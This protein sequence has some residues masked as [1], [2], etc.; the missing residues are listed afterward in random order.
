M[1][2]FQQ[3][4]PAFCDV[5]RPAPVPFETTEDLLALE[6]VRRY[7]KRPDF[8]HFAMYDDALMEISDGGH[9]WWLV[10]YVEHPEMVSLPK[11]TGGKYRAVLETG[12]RVDLESEDVVESCGDRLTLRD[13]TIA[14]RVGA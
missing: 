5:D 8:S 3:H 2:S 13:G 11:W 1:N 4:I 7:G 14:R 12:E 10:G 6:I 9:Y